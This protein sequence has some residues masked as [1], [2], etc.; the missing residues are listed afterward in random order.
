MLGKRAFGPDEIG[1]S[2]SQLT[3]YR[4]ESVVATL[5]F[6]SVV[7]AG[8]LLMADAGPQ[9]RVLDSH[10][11]WS[12][13]STSGTLK[14]GKSVKLFNRAVQDSHTARRQSG[15]STS[16]IPR[17]RGRSRRARPRYRT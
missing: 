7:T 1:P 4:P 12:S 17:S 8:W 2:F 9:R 6:A 13:T 5:A 14:R 15:L 11:S 10:H 3:E 16:P